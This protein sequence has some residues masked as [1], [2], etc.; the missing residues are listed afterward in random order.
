MGAFPPFLCDFG[1][2]LMQRYADNTHLCGRFSVC[3]C[4]HLGRA[5]A[6]RAFCG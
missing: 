1:Y 3:V 4:A 2:T 5:L 6:Q